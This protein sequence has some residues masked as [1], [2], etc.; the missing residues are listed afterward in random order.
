MFRALPEDDL[1]ARVERAF[2]AERLLTKLGWLMLALGVI[3]IVVVV[4]QLALGNTSWQR[5]A[6]GVLGIVAATVL[7][8]ATAYGA[9]TNV[10]LSAVNLKLRLQERQPPLS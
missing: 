1:H 4:A 6:A 3:G 2:T 5:A 8:G 9:G 7:S 10:G